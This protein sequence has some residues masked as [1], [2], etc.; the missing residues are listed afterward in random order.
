[1]GLGRLFREM[2][3]MQLGCCNSGVNELGL[4]GVDNEKTTLESMVKLFSGEYS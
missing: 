3:V 1:M 4:E 2:L